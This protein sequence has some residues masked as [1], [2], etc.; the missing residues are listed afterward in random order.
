LDSTE[1]EYVGFW[2]RV[3]AA[4]IDVLLL[5]ILTLPLTYVV[6]GRI[7]D[8]ARIYMGFWD[9]VINLFVPAALSIVLW[10]KFGATPGKLAMSARVVDA[11]TGASLTVKQSIVRYLGYFVSM[12]PLLVGCL[13][14]A[15]DRKKQGWHDKIANTVVVRPVGKEPVSFAPHWTS[16]AGRVDPK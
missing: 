13:W 11:D 3:G 6:Y 1:L 14:V 16:G 2:P 9:V 12:L 7:S 15:F 5:L 8:P 10:V 4:L